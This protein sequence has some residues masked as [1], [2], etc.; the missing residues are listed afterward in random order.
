LDQKTFIKSLERSKI[1]LVVDVRYTPMSRKPGFSKTTL[2]GALF[3]AGIAYLHFPC[4]GNP[5][6]IRQAFCRHGQIDRALAQYASYLSTKDK[7][8]GR[9]VE[10]VEE[11]IFCL[12]CLEK[13]Y[14]HCHRS[15]VANRIAEL[16]GWQAAHLM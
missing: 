4:L 15:V 9:L 14:T 10:E 3:S 7:C 11:M 13:D 1:Q 8:L 2:R 12:L 6:R 5:P 16:T